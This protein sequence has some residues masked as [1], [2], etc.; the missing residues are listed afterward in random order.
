MSNY[1]IRNVRTLFNDRNTARRYFHWIACK[2]IGVTPRAN[3]GGIARIGYWKNFS[4]FNHY[5]GGIAPG[6]CA[7]I[8]NCLNKKAGNTIAFDV[9]ANLGI[10]TCFMGRLGFNQIHAFEAVPE[11]WVRLHGNIAL[12]DLFK[13]VYSCCVALNEKT[14][15][16]QFELHAAAPGLNGLALDTVS[17]DRR[18]IVPSVTLDEYCDRFDISRIHFMKIDVE[19]M[20]IYVLKGARKL[21][22]KGCVDNILI[23]VCPRNL[24]KVGIK[25]ADL[26]E[27]LSNLGLIAYQFDINGEVIRRFSKSDFESFSSENVLLRNGNT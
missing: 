10:F 2:L 25:P 23:E 11:T 16:L 19:G 3:I 20:E 14:E 18:L 27:D 8:R 15:F 9:G 26:F 17:C 4:E 13:N 24:L 5:A 22:G 1:I 12:N 6:E 21:L 7:L